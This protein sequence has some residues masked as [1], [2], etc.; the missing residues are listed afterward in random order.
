MAASI[1]GVREPRF[2]E[3]LRARR[4]KTTA[5]VLAN[6]DPRVEPRG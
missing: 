3:A 5:D 2:R 4:A 1:L 6:R